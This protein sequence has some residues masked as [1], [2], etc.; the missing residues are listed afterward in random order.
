[1]RSGQRDRRAAQHRPLRNRNPEARHEKA[2]RRSISIFFMF[3]SI[4]EEWSESA[5]WQ[6]TEWPCSVPPWLRQMP[7]QNEMSKSESN[8]PPNT[9][10]LIRK[11]R[12]S[13]IEVLRI[14]SVGSQGADKS[15]VSPR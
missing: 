10:V 8:Q 1:M 7:A 3:L 11:E 14:R 2:K 15:G 5:T 13:G 4:L 6:H 9:I 12:G